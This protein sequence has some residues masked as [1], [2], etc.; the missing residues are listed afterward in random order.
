VI[1]SVAAVAL[2][3]EGAMSGDY[4]LVALV[5]VTYVFV[6]MLEGSLRMRTRQ[7]PAK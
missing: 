1:F 7:Q 5:L 3:Y 4:I 2:L 6:L